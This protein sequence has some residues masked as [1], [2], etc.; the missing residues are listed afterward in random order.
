M[1]FVRQ[2]PLLLLILS[3][4]ASSSVS[5][6][7]MKE[8]DCSK[9]TFGRMETKRVL[10][11]DETKKLSKEGI[12]IL[13][14]VLEQ[15][16]LACW[17]HSWSQKPLEKTPVKALVPFEAKDKLASGM[18]VE[19]IKKLSGEVGQSMVLL[20]TFAQ[21][22][23]MELVRYGQILYHKDY[24][25]RLV[26]PHSQL[27]DLLEYPCLRLFSLVKENYTPDKK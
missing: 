14:Y 12:K 6:I 11:A 13:E 21:V 27:E 24:F 7:N 1:K 15:Q 2:L 4:C 23:S 19:H 3:S 22:D 25:Y 10:N 20:Q 17:D 8:A 5:W 18:N 16:Y 9:Y 26:V